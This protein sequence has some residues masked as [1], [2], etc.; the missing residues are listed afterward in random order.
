M[1]RNFL[2]IKNGNEYVRAFYADILYIEANGRYAKVVTAAK[3]YLVLASL[4]EVESSLPALLFCRIHKSFIISLQHTS[5][6]NSE[7]LFV[8]NRELPI[9]R[10]YRQILS[11]RIPILCENV[12]NII[13]LSQKDIDD[14]TDEVK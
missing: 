2:F 3:N 5:S 7:R 6:F 13:P 10:H 8:A 4:S 1:E 12:K 11:H 9:G 14:L